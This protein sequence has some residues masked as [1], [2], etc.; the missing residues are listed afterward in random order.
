MAKQKK[1][2]NQPSTPG[3]EPIIP[4]PDLPQEGQSGAPPEAAN[5]VGGMVEPHLPAPVEADPA[6]VNEVDKPPTGTEIVLSGGIQGVPDVQVEEPTYPAYEWQEPAEPPVVMP[7]ESMSDEELIASILHLQGRIIFRLRRSVQDSWS[8]GKRL[9]ILFERHGVDRIV[10]DPES[11]KP[12][13]IR[14]RWRSELLP[15]LKMNHTSDQRLRVLATKYTFEEVAQ[16]SSD[17]QAFDACGFTIGV[18]R[19]IEHAKT[20]VDVEGVQ[21]NQAEPL[22]PGV[23]ADVKASA[24]AKFQPR[25]L[26]AKAA[27]QVQED[28]PMAG[29]EALV[30]TLEGAE[31]ADL[32]PVVAESGLTLLS[33]TKGRVVCLLWYADD[34]YKTAKGKVEKVLDKLRPMKGKAYVEARYLLPSDVIAV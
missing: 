22:Q 10:T 16:F 4:A 27:P 9:C 18:R 29:T 20:E 34:S 13:R 1:N 33:E 7:S 32:K 24:K 11:G 3:T 2:Q 21:L 28:D 19:A 8:I 31:V 26:V 6:Q 30:V 17:T 25:N 23:V 12:R 15:K 14:S 5:P